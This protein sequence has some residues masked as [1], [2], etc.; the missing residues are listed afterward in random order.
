[1]VNQ[2]LNLAYWRDQG[3]TCLSDLYRRRY[4]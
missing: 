3:L 2:A 4:A 1:L